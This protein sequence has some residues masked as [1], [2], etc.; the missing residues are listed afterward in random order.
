MAIG[1]SASKNE[2]ANK[3]SNS[4]QKKELKTPG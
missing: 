2:S 3:N 1:N 4:E